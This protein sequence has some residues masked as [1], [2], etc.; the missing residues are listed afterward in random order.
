MSVSIVF[1]DKQNQILVS[2][3]EQVL[4][5]VLKSKVRDY[6]YSSIL[7]ISRKQMDLGKTPEFWHISVV[8]ASLKLDFFFLATEVLLHSLPIICL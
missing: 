8:L 4:K 7:K 6:F 2:S 1:R 5:K 3:S